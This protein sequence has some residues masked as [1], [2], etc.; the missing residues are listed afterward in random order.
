MNVFV[1]RTRYTMKIAFYGYGKMGKAI[2]EI[3]LARGHEVVLSR[4]CIQCGYSSN[5]CGC[6]HRVQHT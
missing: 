6:G 4:G 1:L 5:R 3:A 2:E